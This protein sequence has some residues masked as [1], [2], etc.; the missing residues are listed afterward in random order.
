MY[1][2][3]EVASEGKR[4]RAADI[5]S[6]GCVFLEMATVLMWPGGF[7]LAQ[8]HEMKVTEDGRKAYHLNMDKTLQWILKLSAFA[9][10]ESEV[11]LSF[12]K[13]AM[14]EWCFMMVQPRPEDR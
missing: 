14:L 4:G 3:P 10:Q 2:A 11:Y 7:S 6:L 8:F 5:F 9:I 13:Y 12:T 1:C